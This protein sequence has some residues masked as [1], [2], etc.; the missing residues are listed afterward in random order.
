MRLCPK[1]S[2]VLLFGWRSEAQFFGHLNDARR[3][4]INHLQKADAG[5]VA[6]HGGGAEE[7]D[8]VENT[9]RLQPHSVERGS[10]RRSSCRFGSVPAIEVLFLLG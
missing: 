10:R 3:D 1:F 8:V 4:C 6:V 9:E 7:L 2:R 5:D